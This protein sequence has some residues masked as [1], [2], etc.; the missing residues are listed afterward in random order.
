M[1]KVVE[2]LARAVEDL[3]DGATV[4]IS[5]FGL[6]G[7]PSELIE[8]VVDQ[9]ARDLTVVCNNGGTGEAGLARL[10]NLGRV[11]KLI[12]SY[13]RGASAQAFETAFA[14]G[15][16]EFECVPQGTLA[17]RLRAAGAGLGGFFTPTGYGTLLAAGKETRM[18]DGVGHV[19]ESPLRADFALVK[20]YRADPL[21]NLVYRKAGRNF[22]PLMCM[23]ARTTVAQVHALV[24][25]GNLDPEH[26]VTPGIFVQRV[27]PQADAW[28]EGANA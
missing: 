18:I 10:I 24:E 13:P 3:P 17:E 8:A 26:I 9:G 7:Q 1:S 25:A 4:L 28:Y 22:G 23:A 20:A 12:A 19:F 2:S 6:S 11:H 27:V 14:A 21:G 15:R 5:G 16:L